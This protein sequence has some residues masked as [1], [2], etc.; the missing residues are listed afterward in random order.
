M[1]TA[2]GR[3]GE[4]QQPQFK[5]LGHRLG[6]MGAVK[7]FLDRPDMRAGGPLRKSEQVPD[8]EIGKPLSQKPEQPSSCL[9]QSSTQ[10]PEH[11]EFSTRQQAGVRLAAA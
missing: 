1:P 9:I 4:F 7:F 8:F 5:P 6:P 10:K 3:G 2:A 11:F